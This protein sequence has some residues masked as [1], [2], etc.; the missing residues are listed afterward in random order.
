MGQI[1]AKA[2][3]IL[4]AR[5]EDVYATI[6]DYHEG[7]PSILPRKNLYDLRVE[8]GG[9]GAGTIIRFK[10]RMLGVEQ[11]FH[12]R[13]SEPE[14][15]RVLVEQDIEPGQ[16]VTT[17]FT[18]TPLENGEKSQV[19]ICTTLN[20][21]PGLRGLAE[22]LLVP[23]INPPIYRKELKLLETVARQRASRQ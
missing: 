23:L 4:D 2:V 18:V 8:Q 13:V 19:E 3:D 10:A 22:R 5:P 11:S 1:S 20:A 9:Y 21:S 16:N 14:P 7:H 17:M 15:G 12:H 6:A